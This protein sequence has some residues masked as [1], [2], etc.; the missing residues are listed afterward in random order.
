MNERE[1]Q[2]VRAVIKDLDT[3]V[4]ALKHQVLNNIDAHLG[5]KTPSPQICDT[6][7]K[8]PIMLQITKLAARQRDLAMAVN[9]GQRSQ[10]VITRST[11]QEMGG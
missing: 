9:G 4:S 1:A 10:V 8:A 11:T 2:L 6:F 5:S 7:I 3:I